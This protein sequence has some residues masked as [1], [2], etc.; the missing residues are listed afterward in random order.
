MR[1][2]ERSRRQATRTIT[3]AGRD[4]PQP[5]LPSNLGNM[6]RWKWPHTGQGTGQMFSNTA[7]KS[8]AARFA[9]S[10]APSLFEHVHAG[11][12]PIAS[13]SIT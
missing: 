7:D 8:P 13:R 2:R 12:A 4:E 10:A 5:V 6:K 3:Q 1:G 9:W 11:A